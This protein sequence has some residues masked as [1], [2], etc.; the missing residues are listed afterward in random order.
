[1]MI[2]LPIENVGRKITTTPRERNQNET[3]KPKDEPNEPSTSSNQLSL[4][5]QSHRQRKNQTGRAK[6]YGF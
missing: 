3:T 4:F 5:R 1:M 6:Q 2:C